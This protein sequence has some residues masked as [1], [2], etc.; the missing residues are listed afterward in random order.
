MDLSNSSR[1][2]RLEAPS[3]LCAGEL[4]V[5][6]WGEHSLELETWR[7]LLRLLVFT[8]REGHVPER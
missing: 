5:G 1:P 8:A 7:G 6:V 2:K 3:Q 4:W